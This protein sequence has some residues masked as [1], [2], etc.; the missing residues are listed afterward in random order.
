MKKAP[1]AIFVLLLTFSINSFAQK[2]LTGNE[3]ADWVE[4]QRGIADSL[5]AKKN[6]TPTEINKGVLLLKNTLTFL[7]SLPIKGLARGNTYLWYQRADANRDLASGYALLNKKDSALLALNRM[8]ENGTRTNTIDFLQ[9][10]PALNV[11][12]NEPGYLA[13]KIGRAHV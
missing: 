9:Q 7:D 3:A 6:V 5:F 13:I 12:R 8:Y 2:N 10:N 1:I 4:T 11:L